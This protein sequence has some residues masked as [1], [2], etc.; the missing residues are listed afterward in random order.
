M[1]GN[2]HKNASLRLGG[3]DYTPVEEAWV[4]SAGYLTWILPEIK[5]GE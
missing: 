5:K 3:S 1:T 4:G 2:I